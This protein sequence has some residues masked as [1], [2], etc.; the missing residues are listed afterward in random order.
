MDNK[1]TNN[2]IF[3]TTE[4]PS[5]ALLLRYVNNNIVK[6]EKRL[7]EL[8]LVDCEM[9]N[10]MVEGFQR[11]DVNKLENHL[12]AV[13]S[14]IDLAIEQYSRKGIV[15]PKFR[16]Y[17]A[18][19][20]IFILGLTGMLYKFYFNSI[21]ATKVAEL[22]KPHQQ[23]M[24]ILVDTVQEKEV[25]EST[26]QNVETIKAVSPTTVESNTK[27]VA[28]SEDAEPMER[29]SAAETPASG[30][31]NSEELDVITD[32]VKAVVAEKSLKEAEL[33]VVGKT[34]AILFQPNFATPTTNS[35]STVVTPNDI[36]CSG[37]SLNE[38]QIQS[39]QHKT[40]LWKSEVAKKS[41]SKNKG[42]AASQSAAK[43]EGLKFEN[44]VAMEQ[45]KQNTD[46]ADFLNEGLQFLNQKNYS[47][48]IIKFTSFLD[49]HPKHCEALNGLAQCYE[50]TNQLA[51]SLVKY[52]ELSALK[53]NKL[54]DQAY[55][56]Q[57]ALYIKT[58]QTNE[59]K[60]ALQKAMQSK[61][62]E[63]AEQAKRELDKL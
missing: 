36:N 50:N 16:W 43:D 28:L 47:Q 22:P 52:K 42:K 35:F 11:M 6:E 14:E 53:C 31:K 61:F 51:E 32:D 38:V 8:H 25:L 1:Y 2:D 23:E 46:Q 40:Y 21:D 34:D 27:S 18:A 10:D 4:C 44:E 3:K 41:D 63:I 33:T 57:A 55:L 29:S 58:K 56:K 60:V 62:L 17:Y 19:A 7:V 5:D 24:P 54:S 49:S 39:K 48:A 12:T 45:K 30:V 15:T 37:T 59:A 20:A 26:Q 13:H 9:C